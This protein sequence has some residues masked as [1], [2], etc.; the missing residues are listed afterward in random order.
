MS[1]N[2]G[3]IDIKDKMPP[4]EDNG[5]PIN[6]LVC[7]DHGMEYNHSYTICCGC[8]L[9]GNEPCDGWYTYMNHKFGQVG[10]DPQFCN[11]RVIAWAFLPKPPEEILWQKS[12]FADWIKRRWETRN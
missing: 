9:Y 5:I 11:D 12:Q 4:E 2:M 3:W 6:V 1:E 8:Y 7:V 10:T